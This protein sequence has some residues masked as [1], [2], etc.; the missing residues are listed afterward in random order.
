MGTAQLTRPPSSEGHSTQARAVCPEATWDLCVKHL[1][2]CGDPGCV[3][4]ALGMAGEPRARAAT[5]CLLPKWE[6]VSP[7]PLGQCH[8]TVTWTASGTQSFSM[9]SPHPRQA[10]AA[11][12]S[13]GLTFV[14]ESWPGPATPLPVAKLPPCPHSR[15]LPPSPCSSCPHVLCPS[16]S[17]PQLSPASSQKPSR[18]C[19][20]W[21]GSIW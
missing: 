1:G 3:P 14:S 2:Q 5:T 10:Q 8:H 15:P 13:C 12:L 11:H 7:V 20:R 18:P 16:S 19:P 4:G 9:T 17:L 21:A 6:L